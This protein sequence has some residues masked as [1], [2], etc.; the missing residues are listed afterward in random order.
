MH[1]CDVGPTL[2]SSQR[3][4]A[5]VDTEAEAVDGDKTTAAD[6]GTWSGADMRGVVALRAGSG[7]DVD[8]GGGVTCSTEDARMRDA[9]ILGPLLCDRLSTSG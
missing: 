3:S 8:R 5:G 6:G 1:N 2:D 7:A 4:N 9:D